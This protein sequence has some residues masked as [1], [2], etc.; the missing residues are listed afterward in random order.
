MAVWLPVAAAADTPVWPAAWAAGTTSWNAATT[1]WEVTDLKMP[2]QPL[3]ELRLDLRAAEATLTPGPDGQW[4]HVRMRGVSWVAAEPPGSTVAPLRIDR[5][6][7][8]NA[9]FNLTLHG[10]AQDTESVGFD[11]L[12]LTPLQEGDRYIFTTD[13]MRIH[14]KSELILIE[15]FS[16]MPRLSVRDF[17]RGLE[18]RA[19]RMSLN[20]R[21]LEVNGADVSDMVAKKNFSADSTVLDGVFFTVDTYMFLP[22]RKE[23]HRLP[24]Q[25]LAAVAPGLELGVIEITNSRV[26][27]QFNHERRRAGFLSFGDLRATVRNL[28]NS[29][30]DVPLDLEIDAQTLLYDQGLTQLT[31]RM[32]C[33]TPDGRFWINGRLGAMDFRAV[34]PVLVTEGNFRVR[35]GAVDSLLFNIE[36]NDTLATGEAYPFYHNLK[37]RK[38]RGFRSDQPRR[39]F[40]SIMDLLGIPDRNP[41]GG[42]LI[43]GNVLYPRNPQQS[44]LAYCWNA[45]RTGI[46]SV[47]TPNY[48]LPDAQE[49]E[50]RKLFQ[51]RRRDK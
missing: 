35:R 38:L 39:F 15:G 20:V 9:R 4:A 49:S 28:S 43:I 40:S 51:L 7:M 14:S 34:N 19:T 29:Q 22:K 33:G 27:V 26:E 36:A 16:M 12:F 10:Y 45:L 8:E 48:L 42:K 13:R 31:F 41:E 37:A 32:P 17:P 1:S 18:E 24:H 44:F 47:M 11:S 21:K 2:Y 3:A 5:L 6:E 23:P 46:L 50:K 25:L 30:F